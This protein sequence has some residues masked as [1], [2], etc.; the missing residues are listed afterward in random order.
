MSYPFSVTRYG[1]LWFA[2]EVKNGQKVGKW[3]VNGKVFYYQNGVEIPEK[4]YNTPPEQ[5]DPIKLLRIDNAQLRMA[6]LSKIDPKRIAECGKIVH[7]DGDMR[8]YDIPKMDVRILR[9]RCT[10]TKAY[11]YL[12]VPKDSKQC[13]QARQWTFGVGDFIQ[14]PIKF[15]VET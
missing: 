9:V 3:V 10:T 1:K 12:R 13:E 6:M 15:E 14:K 7:K 4:L 5:L 11:Y 2:G 8:L